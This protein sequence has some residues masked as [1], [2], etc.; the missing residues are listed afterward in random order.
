MYEI[1]DIIRYKTLFKWKEAIVIDK[2][3][4]RC[5]DAYSYPY[6]TTEYMIRTKK[7]RIKVLKSDKIF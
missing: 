1:G 6:T 2:R 4:L 3:R 5:L 7:N